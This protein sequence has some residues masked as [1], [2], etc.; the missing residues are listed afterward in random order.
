M[1]GILNNENDFFYFNLLDCFQYINQSQNY[2][3]NNYNNSKNKL[4]P[5]RGYI[6]MVSLD[7]VTRLQY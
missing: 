7:I 5:Q 1:D 3:P 2:I 6:D 4:L